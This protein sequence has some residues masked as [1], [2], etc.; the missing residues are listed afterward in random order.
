[1]NHS[2]HSVTTSPGCLPWCGHFVVAREGNRGTEG[3]RI[4][5]LESPAPGMGANSAELKGREGLEGAP[6][7]RV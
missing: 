1:M 4:S 5:V 2:V 3:S 6:E 7:S